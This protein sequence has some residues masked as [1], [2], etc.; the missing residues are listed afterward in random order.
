MGGCGLM[1]G[2]WIDGGVGGLIGEVGGLMGR[3]LKEG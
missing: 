3:I 2:G 1:G